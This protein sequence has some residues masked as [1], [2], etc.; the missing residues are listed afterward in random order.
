MIP[1]RI[2]DEQLFQQY[3]MFECE[4]NDS[5]FQHCAFKISTFKD[6]LISMSMLNKKLESMIKEVQNNVDSSQLEW[7]EKMKICYVTKFEICSSWSQLKDEKLMNLIKKNV[8]KRK[9][10]RFREKNRKSK[11]KDEKSMLM[12]KRCKFD[13]KA[14][15]RIRYKQ[16]LI[17]KEKE[18]E[19]LRAHADTILF[20]VR[21]KRNDAKKFLVILQGLKTLRNVKTTIATARGETVFCRANEVFTNIIGK[22]MLWGEID[23]IK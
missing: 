20:D 23:R 3:S 11:W 15:L 2:I 7:E 6:T 5:K 9:K 14:N 16:M 22:L 19:S 21:S 17:E 12:E 13:V 4:K 18:E 10:K 1:N 8:E